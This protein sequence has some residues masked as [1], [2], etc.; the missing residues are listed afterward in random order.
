MMLSSRLLGVCA[1]LGLATVAVAHDDDPKILDR[2]APYNGPGFRRSAL[3]TPAALG[4]TAFGTQALGGNPFDSSGIQL[5]SWIPLNQM[6]G[7]QS[8]ADCWGY[9]SASGREYALMTHYEGTTFVEVTDPS[10]P[11]VLLTKAGPSSLW[12]DIK[13]YQDKAYAVSEAGSGIQVFNLANIDNGTVQSQ[14][15]IT[16]GGDTATHNVAINEDSGFLYRTG[17]GG[18]GLRIYDLNQSATNPPLVATWTTRYVHDAQ[19]VSYTTG[20]YAGR[21]IAFCCA[22]FN[23]GY[24][25]TGLTIVDV[26]NKNNLQV[27]SNTQYSSPAYSH[28][29]WLSP[30][31]Q[32]FY[33]GDELDENG[34]LKTT[35]YVMDVSNLN[36]PF[37]ATS[38]TNGNTAIGHNLY[39]KGTDIFEANYRSGLRIFDATNPLNVSETAYF[40]T[41]PGSDSDAFN[42]LWNVYPYFASGTVIGSDMER[43]LFVWWVGDA[44][45]TFDFPGGIPDAINPAG[46]DVPVT[47]TE[48]QA[49]T[50]IG[51]TAFLHYD[52][53]SGFQTVALSQQSSTDFTAHF[54]AMACGGTVSYYLT[55]DSTIGGTWSSPSS[56]PNDLYSAAVAT[57]VTV[58]AS[59][60]MEVAS[61]WTAGIGGDTASTGIW[62]R[63]NPNPTDAAPADDHTQAGTRCYVTGQGSVGGSLGENDV[64]NG[65]TTLVSPSYDLSAMFSPTI[66][67]WRWYVNNGNG[68]VDDDFIVEISNN[69]SNWVEAERLTPGSPQAGGGWFQHSVRVLDFVTLSSNVQLRFIAA[70]EG[71]GS[72]VEAAID[73]LE[74][75]DVDCGP[76]A[77]V[78]VT[79]YCTTSPN[80]VGT[81]ALLSSTGSTSV[82]ANDFGLYAFNSV[83]NVP[84]IF[85]YGAGQA[86]L[87]FGNGIR[88]VGAAGVGIFRLQ[89]ATVSS[90][91]G[92]AVRAVDLTSAPAGSGP[93]QINAGDTWYFQFWYRDVAAGGAGF[94]LS[95]AIAATF[96]P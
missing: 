48:A 41:Y 91:F 47:I 29:G 9:T 33:L 34:T 57:G 76:C 23:N 17:G 77:G 71:G 22:G 45:L 25:Q 55:A 20:P 5:M 94:N 39:T 92:D 60:D 53:G 83:P 78:N 28:Q 80:S 69:G 6:G 62:I 3:G 14:G 88:C 32:Y 43:G 86:S 75:I 64:D 38:F 30:D 56:A 27:L 68:T 67:Y 36:S 50:L 24:T 11:V 65:R 13:V 19:I 73:D 61:G 46:E 66:S 72:I 70:D 21:E 95:D 74:V 89:P 44:P 8:G 52:S 7:P 15:T 96:C 31:K 10:N 26:T 49:G 37:E 40:D 90:A 16:T 42:G 93:G 35:T 58:V 4:G 54:P 2:E 18:N 82:G 63:V 12:R 1:L 87:P 79:N 51:G 81:G 85:Y 84:G 59:D